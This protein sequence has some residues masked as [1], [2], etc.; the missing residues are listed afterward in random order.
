MNQTQEARVPC[1]TGRSADPEINFLLYHTIGTAFLISRA[2]DLVNL[3][4]SNPNQSQS[5]AELPW[6][7]SFGATKGR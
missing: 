1:R 2:L 7:Q 6:I 4:R 5:T 3:F